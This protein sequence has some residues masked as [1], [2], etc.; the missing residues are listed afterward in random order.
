[1]RLGDKISVTVVQRRLHSAATTRW[2][3]IEQNGFV[4]LPR[5]GTINAALDTRAGVT[6]VDGGNIAAALQNSWDWTLSTYQPATCPPAEELAGRFR[7]RSATVAIIGL[8]YVGLPLVQALLDNGLAV[9][10]IDIDAGKV[11]ALREGRTYIHH[12]PAETFHEPIARGRFLPST[13]FAELRRADAVLI[14]VP[15]PLTAHREPDLT[16]VENTARAIAP[17]IKPGQLV[18]LESTTYPGTTRDVVKPILE[19]SGLKSGRDFFI[20]FS[21]EREDPGNKKFS[22][23]AIPKVIGGDGRD[24]AEIADALY[25]RSRRWVG[26]N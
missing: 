16:Y 21:P 24:A 1:L 15:T 10:G 11:A 26:R 19:S 20:A 12:L 2:I 8:G 25:S 18:V 23:R 7:G 3:Q 4:S 14:C 22:T 9:I 5:A 13:D 17:H 6:A